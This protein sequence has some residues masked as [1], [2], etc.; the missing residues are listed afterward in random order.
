LPQTHSVRPS[1]QS[2]DVAVVGAGPYGLSVAAHLLDAKVETLVC[3]EPMASWRHHMPRGMYLKSQFDASSLSAPQG[4]S[5]IANY[6]ETC[7]EAIPDER[8]PIPLKTFVDYGLWFQEKHVGGLI[9]SEVRRLAADGGQF[10]IS[11]SN[12]AEFSA[13]AVVVACG[14][15]GY[16]YVPRVFRDFTQRGEAEDGRVSHAS[17]HKDLG[18]FAGRT[19]AVV[20]AGQSALESAVLLSEAGAQVYLLV[21]RA[22]V[23]WGGPPPG[24][25]G[26]LAPLL[27]P[28]SPLGPGWSLFALSRAPDLVSY[29]PRSLRLFLT[30]TVLGPSG[31]WWLRDRCGSDINVGLDTEV[32]GI[33]SSGDKVALQ[34]RQQDGSQSTLTVDH[35][36]AA[37]GYRVDVDALRF[38]DADLRAALTRIRQTAAPSLSRSFES[39]VRGLYFTGLTAAPTFGT[40]MRFVC[41]TEFAA[42][43][44]RSALAGQRLSKNLPY[45]GLALPRRWN[46][47]SL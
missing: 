35:V 20:G 32:R 8:H 42:G 37:T 43:R 14:H 6:Y 19:V 16:A 29:L 23:L 38:L 5:A 12:G 18:V 31:A 47:S 2:V 27:K 4:G 1:A 26:L 22:S 40:L 13:R 46:Q 3:G 33:A 34:L 44:I 11:L 7:G 28:R 21:R 9:R 25:R 36:I 30:A 45:G 15:L 39:S 41:G 17:Q 10:S 24:S